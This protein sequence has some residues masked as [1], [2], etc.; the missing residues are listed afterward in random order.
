[1]RNKLVLFFGLLLIAGIISGC[2]SEQKTEFDPAKVVK[3]WAGNVE[4]VD[5]VKAAS[6]AAIKSSGWAAD[7]K[8][9]DTGAGYCCSGRR[10]ADFFCPSN[11]H[12]PPRC[13][14]VFKE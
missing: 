1:M 9:R 5:P 13:V 12:K 2:K 4:A 10:Q 3:V 7:I 11:V 14:Q 6:S 8:G